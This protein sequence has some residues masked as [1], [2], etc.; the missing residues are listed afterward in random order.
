[1]S[2]AS[3]G[4]DRTGTPAAWPWWA[5]TAAYFVAACA[6]HL[7]FSLW[8]V[9]P[10]ELPWGRHAL[11]ELVPAAAVIG[12]VLLL[13]AV[14]RQLRQHPRRRTLA[15]GWLLWLLAVLAIDRWLTYSTA[16]YFHYPQYALLAWL[17]AYLIDPQRRRWLPGRVLFWTTLLGA[18]DE[19]LQYLWITA[20]YSHYVDFNDVLVN[21]VAAAAGVLLYYGAAQRPPP[22]TVHRPRPAVEAAVAAALVLVISAGLALGRLQP[23]PAAGLPAGG[24]AR[25]A[26]GA[27]TLHLQRS[28]AQHGHWQRGPYRGQFYV[29]SPLE[30]L[31]AL[32]VG[33]LFTGVLGARRPDQAGRG[34]AAA[35]MSPSKAP[36]S[37]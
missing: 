34:A 6:M 9:R 17:I 35:A 4:G 28:A 7:Q 32:G 5:L 14:A 8:L 26:H 12:A 15:A 29:L 22:G 2:A 21:L 13:L 27:W 36:K 24:L 37:R 31:L 20:H 16:E 10:R 11:A 23:T 1:M 18:V 33:L 30:G 25:D 19:L 3:C